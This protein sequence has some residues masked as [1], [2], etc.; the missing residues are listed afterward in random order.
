MYFL[1]RNDLFAH[2]KPYS[3]RYDPGNGIP[4]ANV[5]RERHELTIRSM[6]NGGPFLLNESGFQVINLNSSM[7]Y[8]DFWD[9][10][11]IQAI[12]LEEVK[13]AMKDNLGA[14]HVH[15]LDYA[16][17]RRH[18]SF[19]VS[20]GQNYEFDQPTSMAHI[21]FTVREGER[22]INVLF[23]ERANEVLKGHWQV[24]NL[25][26]PIK[27][28]LNDWP[29]GLCDA[30]SVDY[31]NDVMAGDIVFDDFY[32]E[33]LQVLYNPNHKWYY[34]PDHKVSEALIFKSADSEH[35]EAPA[36]PHAGFY[37]PNA[38]KDDLRESLD[39]R[40]FV[41]FADLQE[42]PLVVGDVFKAHI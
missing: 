38:E 40:C 3:M 16:V 13:K 29:L 20:T 4:Q 6:R 15:V 33:N 24:V 9:H 22:I 37:N 34:L 41:F 28:T 27:H 7:A 39:C 42:Y 2:E 26:K 11:K 32:T 25:W 14:K 31:R 23:G 1:A 19:P 17:R 8:D 5:I 18:E 30:R 36:S 10:E 35:S 21:D 12:Y